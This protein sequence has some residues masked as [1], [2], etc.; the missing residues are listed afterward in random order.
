MATQETGIHA[1]TGSV[2]AYEFGPF[3]VDVPARRFSQEDKPIGLPSRVFDLPVCFLRHQNQIVDK[4]ALIRAGWSDAFVTDDS[5]T[6]GISV[7][8]RA[9]GDDP[10]SPRFIVTVPRRGY[11]FIGSAKAVLRRFRRRLR[12]CPIP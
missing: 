5:L 1:E 7:L 10:G 8:R 3:R 12:A 6:H 9:L 2:E 4:D 11:Q